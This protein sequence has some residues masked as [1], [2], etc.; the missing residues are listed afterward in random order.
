[1]TTLL[2]VLSPM[3]KKRKLFWIKLRKSL[4]SICDT[5]YALVREFH[6]DSLSANGV[7]FEVAPKAHPTSEGISLSP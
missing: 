2:K 6:P 4:G 5:T 7:E 3:R 1:M